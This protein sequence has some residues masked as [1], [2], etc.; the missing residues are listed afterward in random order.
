MEH[1]QGLN[2]SKALTEPYVRFSE[3]QT[4]FERTINIT[5]AALF[6]LRRNV[7]IDSGSQLLGALVDAAGQEWSRNTTFRHPTALADTAIAHLSQMGVI[8]V[9][10][11]LDDFLTGVDAELSRAQGESKMP[12]S[13]KHLASDDGSDTPSLDRICS[14]LKCP[15]NKLRPVMPL[16]RYFQLARNC[17][18]HRAARASEAL[19][20]HSKGEDVVNALRIWFARKPEKL[21]PLP[22]PTVGELL[23]LSPRQCVL[24][25]SVCLRVAGAINDSLV[26]TL[27]E[28]GMLMMATHHALLADQHSARLRFQRVP[29]KA[30]NSFLSNRYRIIVL[31][32]QDTARRM[33]KIGIMKEASRRHAEIYARSSQ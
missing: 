12:P 30:V 17:F 10:S 9:F 24:A 25:A 22:I 7:N 18:A 19:V 27:G 31:S 6:L 29:E 5:A 3:I 11:A 1:T 4:S 8:Y 26:S 21:S 13:R 15:E 16:L 32:P 23:I 14:A 28:T 33:K 20:A 2:L